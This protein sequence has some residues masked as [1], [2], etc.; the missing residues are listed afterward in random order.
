M[1]WRIG[2]IEMDGTR[3]A[4]A[5]LSEYDESFGNDS[6]SFSLLARETSEVWCEHFFNVPQHAFTAKGVGRFSTLRNT[7]RCSS[8]V[9]SIFVHRR[10]MA[11]VRCR[12]SKTRQTPATCWY[13]VLKLL[14]C[15]GRVIA[16]FGITWQQLLRSRDE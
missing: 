2:H 9:S 12:A 8:I 5:T 1:F 13:L 3:G 6:S 15:Q 14:S 16:S 10:M 11:A 4:P 7:S